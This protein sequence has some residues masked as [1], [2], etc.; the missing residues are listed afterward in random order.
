MKAGFDFGS[1]NISYAILDN[2]EIVLKNSIAHNGNI[3]KVFK[4][5]ITHIK[6]VC[7]SDQIESIGF[8]GNIS[9]KNI[10]VFDPVIASVE[11]NKFLKTG[12]R[13]IFSIGCES[14]YLIRLD[15]QF[16]YI[17][18]VVNSDC[19]SGT[20]GFVDQQAQRLGFS[21]Q[22]LAEIANKHDQKPPSIAT[23][24]AVFAKS[25]IIH[26]QARGHSRQA[27]CAGLCEGVARSVLANTVKGRQMPGEI[28]FTGGMSLNLKITNELSNGLGKKVIVPEEA[29]VFNAV[30]AAVLGEHPFDDVHDILKGMSIVRETRTP[31]KLSLKNYPDFS[32]DPI[33]EEDG[34][35]ITLYDKL[36][37][38]NYKVYIGIDVGSTST[39]A[40][41]MSK[42]GVILA[43]FY[44]RTKGDPVKAVSTLLLKLKKTFSK[45]TLTIL[46]VGTTGSGRDLVCQVIKADEA[47]NEI[48]AHA[49]GTTFI[50][51]DVDT[52]IE[53]GGQDSKFTQLKNGMVTNAVMNYVCAAGTGSFIEEQAKRLSITLDEISDMAMGKKAPYTSDRC[54]VYMER[55]LNIFLSEGWQSDEII[56]AVLY[57]VRDNYLSKVVGKSL[58]GDH[59]YFQGATA[60]NKALVAVFENELNKNIFVSKYCHLTGALGCAV[61]LMKQ[62]IDNSRFSGINFIYEISS[63]TCELCSNQCDI[64]VY[65]VGNKKTAWGLKCG[66][67]YE[68]KKTKAIKRISRFEKQYETI[69]K[70]GNEPPDKDLTVGIPETLFMKEYGFLFKDFFGQLGYKVIIEKSSDKNLATGMKMINADFC[71]PMALSHGIVESLAQKDVD[72]IFFPAIINEQS[73]VKKLSSEEPFMEKMT[74]AYF[75][76]YS[77]YAP[78]IIDNL[79]SY[80]FK[81][82][83][84]SP[85]MKFN[86]IQDE[87]IASDLANQISEVLPISEQD[88]IKAFLSAKSNFDQKKRRFVEQGHKILAKSKDKIKILL[89]G[90]PYVLFDKRVNLGLPLKLEDMGFD[91]VSQSM[92]ELNINII[93]PDHIENMHWYFGQQILMAAEIAA[94]RDDIYPLF[95]TCFRCSPDAY[96]I[97]Y[98][99]EIMEKARKPYLVLQLDEHSSD[100]GYMTRIEAAVDT[101]KNDFQ[102]NYRKKNKTVASH[103]DYSPDYVKPNYFKPNHF[104]KGDTILIPATDAMINKFQKHVFQAAGF[105]AQILDLDTAMMNLG[106]RY[107]SGGECLPN[108]AITGSIIDALQKKSIDPKKS[109]LYLPNICLSCN[110]NQYANLIKVACRNAGFDHIR[111]MNFNG[112]S[113]HP[114]ISSKTNAHLL[115]ITIL[116]SI[117]EKLKHRFQPYEQVKSQ[118]KALVKQSESL[119]KNCIIEKKSLLNAAKE[120]K[121]LFAPIEL[122]LDRKP[123]VGILGDMYAKYNIV[124]NDNI[125][126]YVESLGGE[127]LLPSYNELALHVLHADVVENNMDERL[128]TTMTRYE[129]RFENIFKG[130]IDDS[131]EP[132]QSECTDLVKEFGIH[133]FMAGETAISIGR[134]LYYLKYDRVDAIIHV[135]PLLC[136]PGVISSSILKNIQDKFNIPVIDLFYDGTNKPNKM[137]EPHMF[138]LNRS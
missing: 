57:S 5:I 1:K 103:Q 95:L 138:Y 66:R 2:S 39:K 104:E 80:K 133:T 65:T 32:V 99:K 24:C 30:G 119:I 128:L 60:R 47:I 68:D 37:K 14:F 75:C 134:M 12:C 15:E 64:R 7:K 4:E 117:L 109:I 124:L 84:V 102:K 31:L 123:R 89:L 59:V 38:G 29:L 36:E 82:P 17:E 85:K 98:F 137:I 126:D 13:N 118:T 83:I 74:D 93:K 70:V 52:I 28:L 90:R 125:C 72:F 10:T 49:L 88:I 107:A 101:F 40:I 92:L 53:I 22:K 115:S 50:D 34:V 87:T 97:T 61:S 132:S 94:K 35:E 43:G 130:L 136:C 131:F 23:R 56:A 16:N 76:Y 106:Y 55:D 11:A 41:V 45:K 113:A 62:K 96:L 27:I 26:A 9:L 73:L 111:I 116:S 63:E 91:L 3:V 44:A 114:D 25:D 77:S 78:T 135:N 105:K 129:Q 120:I 8:T 71:A 81:I 20:G 33:Y 67:D 100:V 79:P 69:F 19:A 6:S 18:H 51:P 110:F 42:T 86:N 54:T 48:T 58:I 121:Q 46:G 127:I 108:I 112:L 21:T 122:P